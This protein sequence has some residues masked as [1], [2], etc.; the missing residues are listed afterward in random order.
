[1]PGYTE[2]Q[3]AAMTA[4]NRRQFKWCNKGCR[5]YWDKRG[6]ASHARTCPKIVVKIKMPRMPRPKKGDVMIIHPAWETFI[7]L[8]AE[9]AFQRLLEERANPT[10]GSDPDAQAAL[11]ASER[12]KRNGA[13]ARPATA[14][15]ERPKPDY[16]TITVAEAMARYGLTRE[17]IMARFDAAAARSR[18]KASSA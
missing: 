10:M 9:A 4:A 2:E 6:F 12:P 3:V 14:V 5:R 13:R 16:E 11:D 17:E 1:M 7:N 8:L 18:R 15:E